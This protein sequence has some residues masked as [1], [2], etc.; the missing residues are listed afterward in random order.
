MSSRDQR[1]IL[2]N[3]GQPVAVKQVRVADLSGRQASE[4]EF[5]KLIVH[6]HP[7]QGSITLDIL[8]EEIGKLLKN[9]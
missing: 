7:Y 5:A 2:T 9:E 8:P 1:Q 4:D 6:Q 3:G